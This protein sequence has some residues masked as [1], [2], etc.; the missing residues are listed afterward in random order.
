[1]R[2]LKEVR[3][4]Q[5]KLRRTVIH[6]PNPRVHKVPFWRTGVRPYPNPLPPPSPGR[7][8]LSVHHVLIC[9]NGSQNETPPKP[10][11]EADIALLQ[12]LLSEDVDESNPENV[13]ELL[14]RL[15]AAEGLADGVEERLDGVMDHLDT[16]LS[17]LEAKQAGHTLVVEAAAEVEGGK[18]ESD[19][20]AGSNVTSK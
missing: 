14:K 12:K 8:F 1:M 3:K 18:A 6:N 19:P 2:C 20:A 9:P 11:L 4:Y 5:L 13:A 17:D 7:G 10:S 15:E 16:L